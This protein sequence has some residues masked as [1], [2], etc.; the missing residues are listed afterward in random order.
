MI[1][2][3]LHRCERLLDDS[4]EDL[5]DDESWQHWLKGKIND[6]SRLQFIQSLF[7]R[8]QMCQQAL[9]LS[10][11]SIQLTQPRH[12]ID[13]RAPFVYV[14][15][16][17]DKAVR[18]AERFQR[19]EIAQEVPSRCLKYVVCACVQRKIECVPVEG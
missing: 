11:A 15:D 16:A 10:L 4:L 3:T 13:P 6:V 12:V 5:D 9:T 1:K 18:L 17:V 14:E 19:G 8:L 7:P 2:F